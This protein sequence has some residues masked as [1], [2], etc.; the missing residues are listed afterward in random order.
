MDIYVPQILFL[1]IGLSIIGVAIFLWI[2]KNTSIIEMHD[3]YKSYNEEKLLKWMVSSF[4]ISGGT[5]VL[6]SVLSIFYS[7]INIVI[8]FGL[9]VCL[10]AFAIGIGCNKYEI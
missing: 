2:S 3:D 10:M 1:L 6:A 9:I 4:A 5:I 8:I 7:F